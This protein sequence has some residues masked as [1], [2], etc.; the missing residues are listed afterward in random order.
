M[1]EIFSIIIKWFIPFMLGIIATFIIDSF[2]RNTKKEKAIENGVQSLLRNEL[3]R[4]FREYKSK[5]EMTILD[6]ENM[7]HMFNAYTDLDGNG[8]VKN[9]YDNMSE[10]PIKIV[11]E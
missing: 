11:K 8:T 4:G 7:E 1:M 2:K 3:I 5:G 9:L 10:I 6:K